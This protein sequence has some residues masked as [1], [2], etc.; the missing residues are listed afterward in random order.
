MS[1]AVRARENGRLSPYRFV[2]QGSLHKEN[3]AGSR[4]GGVSSYL[5]TDFD[6]FRPKK[7]SAFLCMMFST[8]S[9]RSFSRYMATELST[10]TQG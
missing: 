1:R 9:G 5:R 3:A 4:T 2:Q 6:Q 10:S 8:T 7:V